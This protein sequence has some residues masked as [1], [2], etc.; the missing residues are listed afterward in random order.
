MAFEPK[1]FN[2][3]YEAMRARTTVLTDFEVGS[4]TRTLYESFAYEM[5][6][7]YQKMQLV[8]QSAFVDSA[9]GAHL[10][11]VVAVLGILRG[12]PDFSVGEVVFIRD[13][14]NADVAIPAGTLVATEDTPEKPKKVYQTVESAVLAQ[15]QTEVTVKVQALERGEEQ[16]A[17]ADTVVVMPRPIPGVK[18][19]NNAQPLRL[20]GRRRETDDELRRRAKNALLSSGKAN[21]AAI[22]NA[23]LPLPGVLDVKVRE[24]FHHAKGLVALTRAA[25]GA[26]AV[27]PK[28]SLLRTGAPPNQKQ[29]RLVRDVLFSA[30]QTTRPAQIESLLEGKAGELP[31]GQTLQ[32]E[33]GALAY[34]VSYTLPIQQ[35]QFGMAEVIVD[36]PDFDTIR[37]SVEQAV[38]SV[39]AAGI[40]MTITG[41]KQVKTDGVFRIEKAPQLKLTPDETIGF[42]EKIRQEIIAHFQSVKMGQ[43]FLFS[44]L[45]K[46]VLSVE[47][48]E[49]L[50][51]F[52]LTTRTKLPDG[53]TQVKVFEPTAGKIEAE[54]LERFYPEH[55][56]VASEDK[57]LPVNISFKAAGLDANKYNAVKSALEAYL[58]GL[59][60][61]TGIQRADIATQITTHAG[62]PS[63][64]KIRPASWCPNP[65]EVLDENVAAT[66]S[67]KFVEKPVLGNLF[68]Y[69]SEV[70]L[71]GAFL[72]AL[73]GNIGETEKADIVADAKT[74]LRTYLDA[75]TPETPVVV[76]DLIAAIQK[77]KRILQAVLD[78]EDLLIKVNGVSDQTR[79][80]QGK[81]TVK[82]FEK[83]AAGIFPVVA[84][85]FPLTVT[86]SNI[87]I[88]VAA[89]A[90][91]DVEDMKALIKHT[92][93][94]FAK[95][96]EPGDNLVYNDLKSALQNLPFGF[97]YALTE[98]RL[99]AASNQ[100]L[101]FPDQNADS[102]TPRDIFA[103]AVELPVIGVALNNINIT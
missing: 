10:D 92:V 82:A 52:K 29:Y 49:D 34:T 57:L 14:G 4:V 66:Y 35:S 19:V 5:G 56:C 81:V 6:L 3:L 20:V 8:Y 96:F 23:V 70:T 77:D 78:E 71:D 27:V 54:E 40:Y 51:N 76:E 9:E 87:G 74:N 73:P 79:L 2:E 31:L 26:E 28:G 11:Q 7:L 24:D 60:L 103:R 99:T 22:E 43:T 50:S 18:S 33:N 86:V 36:T 69:N 48:V 55:L 16:D 61:G 1:K 41:A 12:L 63:N 94:T 38:E 62:A 68:G 100:E 89:G 83:A 59:S 97:N 93:D 91:P 80:S 21:I 65:N 58:N 39:R 47:G 85:T 13:K 102:N 15:S 17:P 88:S 45:M 64:L 30:V 67:A 101:G 25:A 75:L 53:G 44:K 46:A 32:F 90:A 84:G 42:E 72:L 95:D 98:L 37:P